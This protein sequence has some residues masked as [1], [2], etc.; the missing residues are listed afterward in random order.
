MLITVT[1]SLSQI[2]RARNTSRMRLT[3]YLRADSAIQDL[4]RDAVSVI[5]DADLFHS[6]I[7]LIDRS[8]TMVV[9][10]EQMDLDRDDLLMFST[11]LRPL[12]QIEYNGEGLEYETQYR[13]DDDQLGPALWQRRDPVPDD[14]PAGGGIATPVAEG[15]IGLRIEAYDGESWFDE[16]DSD[17]DGM[18][19]ALRF[20]V[21]AIG[22]DDTVEAYDTP[23][24][25]V[26]LQTQ[27]AIDRI[28]PPY[29]EPEEE[30]GEEDG[31]SGAEAGEEGM[32]GA[33]GGFGGGAGGFG[34][35]RGGNGGFNGGGRGGGRGGA[36]GRGGGRGGAG[37]IRGGGG[38]GGRGGGGVDL[39]GPMGGGSGG[40][41]GGRGGQ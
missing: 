2:G 14:V 10:D 7:M 27:V 22:N 31:E 41:G 5:R 24:A 13:I 32:G 25:V 37:G 4:R 8:R 26:H 40:G 21:T 11:R 30:E 18:P 6:R 38:G 12:G 29:E 33:G 34:G 36:G 35:G 9:G 23:G 16:W 1:T 20:T 39:G 28:V 17:Y 15:I 3:A 19:W